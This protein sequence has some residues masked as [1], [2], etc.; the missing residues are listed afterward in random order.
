MKPIKDIQLVKTDYD[1]FKDLTFFI[2]QQQKAEAMLREVEEFK[3]SFVLSKLVSIDDW[4]V[5]HP[6][7]NLE[8]FKGVKFCYYE[9]KGMSPRAYIKVVLG[10]FEHFVIAKQYRKM[11]KYDSITEDVKK[12]SSKKRKILK[13]FWWQT[14]HVDVYYDMYKNNIYTCK[15]PMNRMPDDY[16][17][18]DD[19]RIPIPE[20][21]TLFIVED[22]EKYVDI[23]KLRES[24][25]R[26]C[27]WEVPERF[28]RMTRT[29]IKHLYVDDVYHLDG[30]DYEK[31]YA[32][33]RRRFSEPIELIEQLYH[34]HYKL[35]AMKY[36]KA[37]SGD[38]F[39]CHPS[40]KNC[41]MWGGRPRWVSNDLDSVRITTSKDY[42]LVICEFCD[43]VEYSKWQWPSNSPVTCIKRT[44]RL[45]Y[46]TK[47]NELIDYKVNSDERKYKP[48]F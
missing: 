46:S 1:D 35:S 47:N 24:Y 16:D 39:M 44:C 28:D 34:K 11:P 36:G 29:D 31:I 48:K 6:L 40:F 15:D 20:E 9:L 37:E 41:V 13:D 42:S 14:R 5:E 45:T 12:F 2:K 7:Y 21:S 17:K 10:D 4:I 43:E 23:D 25:A 38:G 22:W 8:L 18:E 26:E 19:N 33:I 32:E 3:K 27:K 30:I